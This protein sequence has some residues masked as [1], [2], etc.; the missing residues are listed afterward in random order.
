MEEKLLEINGLR[1]YFFTKSGVAKAVDGV[2]FDMT[3]GETLG[4]VG[5]SGCGK[6]VMSASIIRL[7]ASKSGKIVDGTVTFNGTD[8]SKLSRE[9]LRK[10]RGS[11]VAMIF[12]DPMTTL[13]PVFK[14]SDQMIEML[15][16]HRNIDR[17]TAAKSV[18]RTGRPNSRRRKNSLPRRNSLRRRSR[19]K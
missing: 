2:S 1:T 9:E 6:S 8:V 5:E 4:V 3:Q 19:K 14:V 17:K 12:Q 16:A 13:D 7:L 18:S 10:L 15:Q 11:D